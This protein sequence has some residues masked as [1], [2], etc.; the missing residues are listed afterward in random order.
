ME[1]LIAAGIAIV[2]CH[3]VLVWV[4]SSLRCYTRVFLVKNFWIDD[5]LSVLSLVSITELPPISH[6]LTAPADRL[7]SLWRHLP[8]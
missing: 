6:K 5:W 4:T 8:R 2:I 7:H 1:Y 3:L